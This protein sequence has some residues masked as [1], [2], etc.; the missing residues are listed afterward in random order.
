MNRA[1]RLFVCPSIILYFGPDGVPSK[2]YAQPIPQVA[3][4]D[5][6]LLL[7]PHSIIRHVL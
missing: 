5:L 7:V 4:S 6:V 1:R 3:R 2:P